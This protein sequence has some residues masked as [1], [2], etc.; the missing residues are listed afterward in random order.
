MI[1]ILNMNYDILKSIQLSNGI[2]IFIILFFGLLLINCI[3]FMDGIDGL[4]A[5]NLL[6]IFLNYTF[7]K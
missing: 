1:Y 6:L 4:V 2:S 5:S 3:N 7:C